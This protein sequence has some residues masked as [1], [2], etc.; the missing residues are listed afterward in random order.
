MTLPL[1]YHTLTR[2]IAPLAAMYLS[3]RRRCGKEDPLRFQERLGIASAMRPQGPLV[4]VHAASVGEA[5]AILGTLDRLLDLR[6]ELHIVVTTGTLTSARLLNSRLPASVQHQFVPADVPQWVARFLD[7]WRP[8]LALWVESELWPNLLLQTHARGVPMVLLNGR[9]SLRSYEGWRRWP[10]LI[11]PMLRA[12]DLCLTQDQTQAERFK[13]LGAPRVAA[14]GDLKAAAADLPFDRSELMQ[15]RSSIGLRPVW[16]AASTHSDEEEIAARV[17]HKLAAVHPGL[18]TII[19]PRHPVRGDAIATM[20]HAQGLCIARRA[21]SE[22]VASETDVYLGD[23][24]GELGLFYRIARIAFIGGSLV[25]KGGHNPF[26]AARLDCAILHGP[27]MSNCAWMAAALAAEGAS[28]AVT[29]VETLAQAVSALL[30]NRQ[31]Q[32][33]RATAAARVAASG[34]HVLDAVLDHLAPWL[35][36]LAPTRPIG[37]SPL[38]FRV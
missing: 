36:R 6:P 21:H 25:R 1:L 22:A 5:A 29:G 23:T 9:L 28:E 7:H 14:V 4:W 12:F 35:D 13:L 26:E 16:L 34:S 10:G 24:M 20:L 2:P 19:V 18:L 31:L 17:H 30:L 38:S 32:A 37:E 3:Y 11:G 15:L 33:E 8:D 27:D